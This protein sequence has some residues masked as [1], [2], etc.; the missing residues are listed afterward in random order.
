MGG[1]AVGR[2]AVQTVER[3][4]NFY[5]E[6]ASSPFGKTKAALYRVPGLTAFATH[7]TKTRWR[8][9]YE[10]AGRLF[11]VIEDR[12]VEID[13]AGTITDRGGVLE[14]AQ[15]SAAYITSNGEGGGEL[16]IESG[17]K[18][19]CYD[20]AT[21]TLTEVV[22]VATQA[23]SVDGFILTLDTTDSTLQSTTVNDGANWPATFVQQ[24]TAAPDPWRAFRVLDR[25]IYLFGE[26]TTDIYYNAA[27][28]NFPF[29]QHTAGAFAWGIAAPDSVAIVAG[30]LVWL[31]RS[32]DDFGAVVAARGTGAEEI[33]TPDLRNVID[34]YRRTSRIDDAIGESISMLGHTFYVLTFPTAD[35]TWVYDV[36]SG[37]WTEWLTWIA[38]EGRY[39][40]W[41]AHWHVVAFG[42][43]LIGDRLTGTIYVLD[44]TSN[45]DATGT[46]YRR[47]RRPPGLFNEDVRL[48][49]RRLRL[50]VEPGVS[51]AADAPA[52]V[53]LN[54]S[55]DGGKTWHQASTTPSVGAA[56]EYR[57][58]PEWTRLG[59]ARDWAFEVV[60]S[61]DYP[62]TLL[63]ALVTPRP[64]AGT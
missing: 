9:F 1:Y 15:G 32:G 40:A 64:G 3:T 52:V 24:R 41:R 55:K 21:N 2:S 11:G 44:P 56:G 43:H 26:R 8:A 19:Y 28:P 6:K 27:L 7:A 10:Q 37:T 49:I 25:L 4:V 5:V 39:T 18:G 22:P 46:P 59:T 17:G 61:D 60:C 20:L 58:R 62:Y 63:G 57:Q 53:V 51:G 31:A 12:F 54:Y 42:K 30:R 36:T 29:A 45:L 16:F 38:A 14:G 48:N 35:A 13:Q 34:G 33:S 23:D 50:L 47:L